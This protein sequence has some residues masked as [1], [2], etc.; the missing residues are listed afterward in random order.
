M[1]AK[2]VALCN[3]L[4]RIAN[5]ARAQRWQSEDDMREYNCR[6]GDLLRDKVRLQEDL[7]AGRVTMPEFTRQVKIIDEQIGALRAKGE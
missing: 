5:D 2:N 1:N 6:L 4:C 7:H 3:A